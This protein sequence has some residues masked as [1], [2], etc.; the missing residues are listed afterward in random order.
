M[1]T[2]QLYIEGTRVDMFK[3]E[4]VSITD[5]IKNVKDVSKV[6][7]E[8]TKTFSLPASKSNN[9]LFKHYYNFDIVGG[10]DAR[11]RVT[12][13]IELNHLPYKKGFIKLEGVKLKNKVAHT[14]KVTFFGNTVSLKNKFGDD[15]LQDLTWLNN[16]N[17]DQAGNDITFTPTYMRDYLTLSKSKTIDSVTYI[18]PVQVPLLTHTQRLYYRTGENIADT[19]NIRYHSSSGS[20]SHLHGVKWNQLKYAMKVSIIMKAIE[21]QYGITFS[22]DFLNETNTSY[23]DLYLWLHRAKGEVRSV[24]QTTEFTHLINDGDWTSGSGLETYMSNGFLYFLTE[25]EDLE[26]TVTLTPAS[27][28]TTVSYSFEIFLFGTSIYSS[29]SGTGTRSRT[30]TDAAVGMPYSVQITVDQQMV[31]NQSRIIAEGDIQG[32]GPF[33]DDYYSGSYTLEAVLPFN[34]TQQ[35]PKM[36]VIDFVTGLF[37]M[38]NLTAYVNQDDDTIVVQTLDDFYDDGG[39]YD[40][41]DFVDVNDSEVD[42]A[43]PFREVT[44]T[45]E[46]LDTFLSANHSQL[47]AKDWGKE[48]FR[49][50]S[51]D[52]YA[53]GIFNYKI[54]F[55]HM[56]FERMFNDD[57]NSFTNFLWGYCVDDNQEPYIGKPILFYMHRFGSDQYSFIDA[58]DADGEA[59][60]R[61]SAF[62]HWRPCNSNLNVTG[63]QPSLNFFPEAD[64]FSLTTNTNTLFNQYHT[65]YITGIFET[66]KRL[67]KFTAYLPQRIL[68]NLKLNDRLVINQQSY[69]INSI[70][71]NLLTGKS[72]L[73]LL[74]E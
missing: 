72:Q 62:Y 38:F 37:K 45:Y 35:M 46:G 26:F 41:S 44:Y 36:K 59:S 1:Q 66:S 50:N 30:V 42:A 9:K 33:I 5:T 3:D 47:F 64:E 51:I 7:T 57:Q 27:G 12:A 11:V 2:I 54:P 68:L 29:G 28:Y 10:F 49:N 19:G 56:K 23:K 48:E 17:T 55:E 39:S 20:G 6:F 63:S 25:G 60:S 4:S 24:G 31:F 65:D 22:T 34:M 53:G 71:T 73:E 18:N 8:F 58:V 15:K 52:V 21:E 74:N 67:S 14:Y 69:K 70:T 40:I 32:D 13:R 16:F 61:V 43:L